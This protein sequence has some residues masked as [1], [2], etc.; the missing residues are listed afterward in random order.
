[1]FKTLMLTMF[2]LSRCSVLI[3]LSELTDYE[4]ELLRTRA[5]LK[6][7]T[8]VRD[9]CSYHKHVFLDKYEHLQKSCCNPFANHKQAVKSSLR[10]IT[11]EQVSQFKHMFG[12]LVTSGSK[13]CITCRK[14]ITEA[15]KDAQDE[16]QSDD[17]DMNFIPPEDKAAA[18]N[19]SI[20]SLPGVSPIKPA[21]IG[22]RDKTSYAKR[23]WEQIKSVSKDKIAEC[24]DVP[25]E[26]F[27]DKSAGTSSSKAQQDIE[28]LVEAMKQKLKAC[29]RKQQIAV[30][31][32][33]PRSWTIPKVADEFNVTH[34]T[35]RKARQLQ[36]D[37]GILPTDVP[38]RGKSLSD[39]VVQAVQLFYREDDISRMMPGAKDF[40]SVREDGKRVHKQR[41]LILM[42]LNELHALFKQRFPDFS[43]GLSKFCELRPKE[44]VTVGARGTHSVC[45]CTIHQNVKLMLADLP[46]DTKITFR[47]LIEQYVCSVLNAD[48]MLH[49]CDKCPGS[50]HLQNY[51]LELC[52][53]GKVR[54]DEDSS[55]EMVNYKQWETTDRTTLNTYTK[56]LSDFIE[57]LVQKTE[58]LITHDYI[59]RHQA[60]FLRNLKLTI[61][62]TQ[63]VVLLD[64]AE[65]YSFVVQDAAQ[66]YH[67]DNTQCTLHPAVI[68]YRQDSEVK[69]TS[70]CF[71]SNC[72]KH[73]TVAV[74]KFQQKLIEYMKSKL[75]T[76]TKLYYFSDGA[77]S[78]Y[79]NFKNFVNLSMHYADFGIEAQ[80]H[81]FATSHGKSPCDGVGGTVKRGAARASLQAATN[82]FLLTPDDL[83]NWCQKNITGIQ[84]VWVGKEE[85]EEHSKHLEERFNNAPKIAGT[86]DN[87][88]FI[89]G[90]NGMNVSR[91]SGPETGFT[92][93]VSPPVSEK[94]ID[95]EQGDYVACFYDRKWWIG[96]V[97]SK[98]EEHNDCEIVFMHPHGPASSFKWP[99]RE[100]V[101]WVPQEHI[102]CKIQVPTTSTGRSYH[103]MQTDR[104]NVESEF[105][106]II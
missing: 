29:D 65:N 104:E 106:K 25:L 32:L 5:G 8:E 98:S 23:K 49:T 97:R 20:S 57:V 42:N 102:L 82:R 84:F 35:V 79:K 16:P 88:S 95:I 13:L 7:T 80:W 45:V 77:A 67:W 22:K 3:Q 48:C 69:C 94:L 72:L 19:E 73:D 62:E 28:Y 18:L 6:V 41:R 43:V 74:H 4:R 105:Q 76:V 90:P 9:V 60:D 30:L 96:S 36:N 83:F 86:R 17:E 2:F 55:C 89:P 99:Q 31:T 37:R 39:A 56:T 1:M 15:N 71:V 101:C 85:I 87:H 92:C 12:I 10:S 14:K 21:H 53:S 46:S 81:F 68:Y 91:V 47:D 64:F 100:D 33:A 93:S 61:D 51:L 54:K 38:A 75:S 59:A 50:E 63:A 24:V 11:T 52:A 40:V 26:A 58:K 34:Y 66:G 44:C 70:L 103:I 27:N 78:Q